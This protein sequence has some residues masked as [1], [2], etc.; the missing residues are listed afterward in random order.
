[1]NRI[2]VLDW[3]F[4]SLAT[5]AGMWTLF[6]SAGSGSAAVEMA[7]GRCGVAYRLVRASTW[8][9]DSARAELLAVNPLGQIPTLQTD[10]G[11]LTER[12]RVDQ[13]A[14]VIGRNRYRAIVLPD[15]ERLG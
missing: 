6:G 12:A 13:G 4:Q 15:V 11:V 9:E 1:M 2:V 3:G 5:L 8:E 10:D 7:L 14:L